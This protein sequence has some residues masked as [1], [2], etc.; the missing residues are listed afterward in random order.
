MAAGPS[1]SVEPENGSLSGGATVVNDPNASGGKAIQF[2]D[3][4]GNHMGISGGHPDKENIDRIASLGVKWWKISWEQGWG[5]V[6]PAPGQPIEYWINYAHSKGLKVLQSC[7][8]STPAPNSHTYVLSDVN[9]F[10]AYC[11]EYVNKGADAIEIGNEWNNEDFWNTLDKGNY[12][13]Q[14][15]IV[16]ATSAA[17][18][19]RSKTIPIIT[20]GWAPKNADPLKYPLDTPHIA[21]GRFLDSSNGQTKANASG[22]AHHPYT[23]L[24]IPPF[25]PIGDEQNCNYPD[26]KDS[27]SIMQTQDV[28]AQAKIRGFDKKVWLTE[29]GGPSEGR[30][31]EGYQH[32]YT[33]DVQRRQ[34][35]AYIDAIDYMRK[36][37]GVP[38]EVVFWHTIRDGESSFETSYSYGLFDKDWNLKPSGQAVV[39]KAKQIWQ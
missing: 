32:T 17:I 1:T 23:F 10:P 33:P 36:Q 6:S 27:N 34:Y 4:W 28:Y 15:A 37:K 22:I 13:L 31:N 20:P 8:K 38:I 29:V 2:K 16:D 19:E 5:K 18:R 12:S 21:M 39:D 25:I 26:R 24:C 35:V 14:A 3:T 7:Q 11:A 9:T 30:I